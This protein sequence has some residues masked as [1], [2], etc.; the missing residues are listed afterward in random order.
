MAARSWY[1][2]GI[3]G[4]LCRTCLLFAC[5]CGSYVISVEKQM[6]VKYKRKYS[7]RQLGGAWTKRQVIKIKQMLNVSRILTIMQVMVFRLR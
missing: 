7:K 4:A 6:G 2:L 1:L 3:R 5:V